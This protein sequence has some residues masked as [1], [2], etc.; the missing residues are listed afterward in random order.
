MEEQMAKICEKYKEW[1]EE[2]IEKPINERIKK[3]RK[4]CK[5]KKCK[6]W[7]LCCNKW[8]CW[9][10]V[11]FLTIVRWIITIVGKWLVYVVCRI[12]SAIITLGL[13]LLNLAGWPVKYLWC[14]IWGR[15][16]LE[17][18]PMRTLQLEV[19][20]IDKNENT[21]NPITE[22]EINERIADA[23]R[24]L[25]EEARI[26]VKR[27]GKIK[28][29][30]SASLYELDASS[31]GSK[32]AEWLKGIFLLWGR[33]SVRY[34]TVY[35]VGE[36]KGALALHLPMYGSVFILAGNPDTSLCHEIGHCLLTVFNAYHSKKTGHLMYV[37][38]TDRERDSGWPKSVPKLSRN[39]RCSMRRSRWLDWS[40]VPFIP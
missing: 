30:V 32:I 6:K 21:K 33:D 18:L 20:I 12:I 26:K 14:I 24:I 4:K 35:A 27:R 31:L 16:D 17:K 39:E 29:S 1:V 13:T 40:W 19:I 23:D 37:P 9:L 2:K 11:F 25:R 34:L 5:K 15:S 28:R 7:C 10:E 22:K 36:I 3:T 8:F 38:W